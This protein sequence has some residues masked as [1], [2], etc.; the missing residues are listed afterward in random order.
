[1]DTELITLLTVIA[2]FG[3][4]YFREGRLIRLQMSREERQH[5]WELE[6]RTAAIQLTTATARQLAAHTTE[7]AVTL[8]AQTAVVSE[9]LEGLIVENTEIS[10][11][12]FHE[13]NTVNL[14]LEKL[15]IAHNAITAA[16][17]AAAAAT[18]VPGPPARRRDPEPR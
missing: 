1:M 6:A 14:K 8:A 10:T 12:A 5:T 18:P 3:Y 16:A 2:G 9:R 13:A 11:Q 15:G 7:T 17:A 4:Q